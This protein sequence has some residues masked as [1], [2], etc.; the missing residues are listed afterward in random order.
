MGAGRPLEAA[1][2]LYVDTSSTGCSWVMS[3]SPPQLGYELG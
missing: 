3:S 1:D 2:R